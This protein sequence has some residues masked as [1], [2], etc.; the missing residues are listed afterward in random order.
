VLVC[1]LVDSVTQ[2]PPCG[3]N[4]EAEVHF[5][6][7]SSFD[8]LRKIC[9]LYSADL[10]DRSARTTFRG[11]QKQTQTLLDRLPTITL[12]LPV[13]LQNQFTGVTFSSYF[14]A[15]GTFEESP[16]SPPRMC[17]WRRQCC[18]IARSSS[19]LHITKTFPRKSPHFTNL[20]Y[21]RQFRGGVRVIF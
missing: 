11:K 9:S 2:C 18:V 21:F 4:N 12:D 10:S 14:P 20:P 6:T 1:C 3:T 17:Q 8:S 16:L 13:P 15:F 7:G 19:E 5:I